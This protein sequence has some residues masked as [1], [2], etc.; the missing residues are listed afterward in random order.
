MRHRMRRLHLARTTGLLLATAATLLT[1]DARADA[2]VRNLALDPGVTVSAQSTY[3]G[4][5]A[6]RVVDGDVNTTVGPNYGW[7][8]A[9]ASAPDGRVPQWLEVDLSEL[10]VI[11]GINLFTSSGYPIQDY[12]LQA[13]N[14]STWGL[15]V[16]TRGNVQTLVSQTF[17]PVL[18][19]KIRLIGIRGP[20]NQVVY[21]RVNELQIMGHDDFTTTRNLSRDPGV[22][23]AAQ[24][25]FQDYS[26]ARTIDGDTN[27]TVGPSY[28]WANAHMTAPDGHVPQWLD[29]D[30]SSPRVI[31]AINLYTSAGYPIQDYDVCAWD[32]SGWI[33]VV[34]Q[35]GNVQTVIRHTFAPV[36]ASKIRVLGIRGP[37]NQVVYVRVNELQIMGHGEL[38]P[39]DADG[40]D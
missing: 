2:P 27:T 16:R 29:V 15:L 28:S 33:T 17:A 40:N 5:S 4:Y 11:E 25:T 3:A 22:T 37:A 14:G 24:S 23:V 34:E 21:V 19:S 7:A 1:T 32:G 13:W 20:V 9:H 35:R 12:D 31:E 6:T 38:A 30:L 39:V 26:A 10:H 18:A 36:L 8:N